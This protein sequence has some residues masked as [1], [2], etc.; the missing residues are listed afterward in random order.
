MIITEHNSLVRL[1]PQIVNEWNYQKNIG[2]N[3]D[4]F[5]YGS[6]KIIWWKCA[7]CGNEWSA[8]IYYRTTKKSNGC[9]KCDSLAVKNPELLCEVHLTKNGK[10]DPFWASSGQVAKIWWKCKICGHEWKTS[11][12]NRTANKKTGCPKCKRKRTNCKNSLWHLN[13]KLSSEWNPIK[14]QGLTPKDFT[15]RSEE[16]ALLL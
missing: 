16:K 12:F 1:Y 10:F 5:S 9:K 3:P 4:N 11:I 14:N 15:I 6:E 8:P 7:K 2:L 13:K